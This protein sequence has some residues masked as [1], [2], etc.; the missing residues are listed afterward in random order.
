M[1]SPVVSSVAR[2]NATIRAV[3]IPGR[4]AVTDDISSESPLTRFL[5]KERGKAE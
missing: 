4:T 3:D 1:R 2:G 5:A